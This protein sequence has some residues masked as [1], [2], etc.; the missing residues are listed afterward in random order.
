M[1]EMRSKLRCSVSK[2]RRRVTR[3]VS[4]SLALILSL[5]SLL[6][7]S[8]DE[9]SA[10]ENIKETSNARKE[11]K[12]SSIEKLLPY[13]MDGYIIGN[14]AKKNNSPGVYS[15]IVSH[16]PDSNNDEQF[17]YISC[18]SK[19][20]QDILVYSK[21][22][23]GPKQ[24]E[25]RVIGPSEIIKVIYFISSKNKQYIYGAILN[26]RGLTDGVAVLVESKNWSCSLDKTD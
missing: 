10:A 11:S 9:L 20:N 16:T 19:G 4:H 2:A 22:D 17:Y 7:F 5:L 12:N 6:C 24:A 14:P 23:R 8:F 3:A 13:K 18:L 1:S 15:D 21:W 26:G 25:V